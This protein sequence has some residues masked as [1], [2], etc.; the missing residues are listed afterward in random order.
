MTKSQIAL[1]PRLSKIAE[2]VGG[3]ETIADIG[4]DHGRLGAYMLQRGLCKRAILTDI[5]ADSLKKA[6]TL[7]RHVG[8][9][10]R[11][12]FGVGSGLAAVARPVQ[13]V[14]VAGMGGATISGILRDGADRLNGAR[15]VLQPNVGAPQLRQTLVDIGYAIDDEAVV[16]DGRRFYVILRAQPGKTD[17]SLI[18]RTVGP[19]LLEKRPESLLPYA[20]FRLRVANKALVGA[21]ASG[22]EA[23]IEPLA[24]EARIWEEVLQCL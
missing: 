18:Q 2:L 21:R 3:C 13:A 11:V 4:C 6:Q 22:D 5:S 9:E 7:I 1:D 24:L 20:R 15:L 12:E 17:Y 8:L 14:V 16:R 10:D 23:Q 19:I